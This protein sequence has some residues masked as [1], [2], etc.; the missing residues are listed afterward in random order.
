MQEYRLKEQVQGLTV[1]RKRDT[2][3]SDLRRLLERMNEDK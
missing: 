3:Y 1:E 2:L